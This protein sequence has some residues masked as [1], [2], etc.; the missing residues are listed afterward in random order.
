[1]LELHDGH[2]LL[3]GGSVPRKLVVFWNNASAHIHPHRQPNKTRGHGPLTTNRTIDLTITSLFLESIPQPFL[4]V[5]ISSLRNVLACEAWRFLN[6]TPAPRPNPNPFATRYANPTISLPLWSSLGF[7]HL[8]S[9]SLF[10][11]LRNDINQDLESLPVDA[12]GS[13]TPLP[14]VP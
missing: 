5:T 14:Y 3:P 4:N 12:K 2:L 13:A 7:Q 11:F 1:M 10:L 6:D 9:L 8:L